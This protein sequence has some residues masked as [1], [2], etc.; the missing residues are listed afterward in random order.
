MLGPHAGQ[1]THAEGR[2]NVADGTDHD[3]GGRL[4]DGDGLHDLLLVDLWG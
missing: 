4:Q 1:G 2:L 3:H